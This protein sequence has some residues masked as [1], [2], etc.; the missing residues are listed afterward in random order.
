MQYVGIGF[1]G[2]PLDPVVF[3]SP[4]LRTRKKT[5][6]LI[7]SYLQV[8]KQNPSLYQACSESLKYLENLVNCLLRKQVVNCLSRRQTGENAELRLGTIIWNLLTSVHFV[9]VNSNVFFNSKLIQ[10]PQEIMHI[11]TFMD[12]YANFFAKNLIDLPYYCISDGQFIINSLRK[13]I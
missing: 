7:E 2:L 5:I 11:S 3:S 1:L 9:D 6:Y 13:L 8:L 10:N 12:T 4:V